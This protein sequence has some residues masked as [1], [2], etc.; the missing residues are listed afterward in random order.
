MANFDF[1]REK[2]LERLGKLQDYFAEY[3]SIP[4]YRYM[5]D[6]L[7]IR[8]KE[9]IGKFIS[10]L[11]EEGFLNQAPDKKLIPAERF[12]ERSLSNNSVQAG[13]FTQ[14]YSEGGEFISID[15]ILITKPSIT[16]IV[17]V[18]GNS[19]KDKGLLDGDKAVVQKRKYAEIN[20]IVVA[21]IRD[22][23][24]IK[25]L[26]RENGKPILI[27]A[28]KNF[29]IIRPQEKDFFIYGVVTGSYRVY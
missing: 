28:N 1:E 12:F 9:A 22:E 21:I 26:G 23:Q 15:R 6:L 16:E 13:Q 29:E 19:M 5:Q 2:N 14:I 4:S 24:T 27:P 7:G 8:S 17:P 11:K 20:E 18:H 10:L 25:T 3:Q